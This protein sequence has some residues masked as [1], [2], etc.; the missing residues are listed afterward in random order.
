MI[1]TMIQVQGC[2]KLKGDAMFMFF[3]FCIFVRISVSD[4]HV[5]L[6]LSKYST[7]D[8]FLERMCIYIF[9]DL[10]IL[11]TLRCIL[12]GTGCTALQHLDV[13]NINIDINYVYCYLYAV[14]FDLI[15]YGIFFY[16]FFWVKI[17][18]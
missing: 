8:Q 9:W 4:F 10:I 17:A 1:T 6:F 7:F 12:F 5:I 13:C 18:E 15:V 14:W 2:T 16:I 11:I 3:C